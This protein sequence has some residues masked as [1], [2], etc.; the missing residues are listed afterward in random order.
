MC[1]RAWRN[2]ASD[3]REPD[4]AVFFDTVIQHSRE[5]MFGDPRWGGNAEYIGWR[6][7]G[8][9]G[10]RHVWAH[11]EQQFDAEVAPTYSLVMD[12]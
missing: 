12:G 3:G 9:P 2:G 4:F 5:G 7:I 6:L 8:Y 10:P 11:E 1:S